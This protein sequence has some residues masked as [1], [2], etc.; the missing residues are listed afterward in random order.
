[1]IFLAITGI[2]AALAGLGWICTRGIAAGESCDD[3]GFD[4]GGDE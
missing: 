3:S 4:Q 1:M 2:A